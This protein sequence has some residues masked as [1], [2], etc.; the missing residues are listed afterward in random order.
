MIFAV[1]QMHEGGSLKIFGGQID[2]RR[3][4]VTLLVGSN[5]HV[6][7]VMQEALDKYAV[8]RS[9]HTQ[10][11][12]V[13]LDHEQRPRF[14]RNLQIIDKANFFF[15]TNTVRRL[16]YDTVA[17]TKS[18]RVLS[19]HEQPL[20]LLQRDTSL[21]FHLRVGGQADVYAERRSEPVHMPDQQATGVLPV[22]VPCYNGSFRFYKRLNFP[23][24]PRLCRRDAGH[25]LVADEDRARRHIDGQ[26]VEGRPS[27]PRR[28]LTARAQ[29]PLHAHVHRRRSHRHARRRAGESVGA[30]SHLFSA[31]NS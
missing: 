16:G 22:L 27:L 31:D 15:G 21:T 25:E 10:Y 24:S 19:S 18:C 26:R 13:E 8:P 3:P 6:Q 1:W 5:D 29:S 7:R 12:L 17:L 20:S 30:H 23:K 9:V 14:V 2:S 28:P 4:Y 11:S